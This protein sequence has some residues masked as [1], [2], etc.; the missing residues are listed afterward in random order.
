MVQLQ[1]YQSQQHGDFFNGY[2]FDKILLI[3]GVLIEIVSDE[4]KNI[5]QIEY[6]RDSS[7]NNFIANLLLTIAL[8]FL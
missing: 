2:I 6:Y 5:A 3:K 1:R 4:L 8:L 7:F